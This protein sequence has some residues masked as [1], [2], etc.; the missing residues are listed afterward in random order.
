MITLLA[1]VE[2]GIKQA[3]D[4]GIAYVV[5]TGVIGF[6]LKQNSDQKADLR[7]STKNSIE[8]LKQTIESLN[9]NS[10]NMENAPA[11][12]KQQVRDAIR[13]ELASFRKET[14]SSLN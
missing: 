7:E 9:K 10:F 1:E 13:E 4:Y 12:I 3:V 8:M 5:L 14:E 6:L 11:T 2:S